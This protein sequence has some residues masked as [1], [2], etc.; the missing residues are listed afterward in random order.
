[1]YAAPLTVMKRVITTKSVEYM[2]FT[3]SFVSFLNGICWTTY[4][5]I[6]FD[7]FITIPK[8]MGTLLCTLQLV[9]YFCYYGSTP[10][11]DN[12]GVELPVTASDGGRN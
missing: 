4:A 3:L 11:G 10:K 12:S 7:I 8:A 6:R 1:M 5:L 2:P 9:L